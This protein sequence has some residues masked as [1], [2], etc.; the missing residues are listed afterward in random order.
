M[1]RQVFSPSR[2]AMWTEPNPP[3][4]KV[5]IVLSGECGLS[6]FPVRPG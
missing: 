3:G 6:G 4:E 1:E 2:G 5:V